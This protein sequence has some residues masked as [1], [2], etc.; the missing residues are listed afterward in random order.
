MVKKVFNKNP[1]IVLN[2]PSHD[3]R[4]YKVNFNL[5]RKDFSDVINFKNKDIIQD[6][7]KLKIFFK[8]NLNC[9]TFV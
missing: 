9:K 1:I 6:I 3:E 8:N 7:K 5:L 4:S 2:K